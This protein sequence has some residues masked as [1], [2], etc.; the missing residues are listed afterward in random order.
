MLLK[1]VQDTLTTYR[2]L[3]AGDRVLVAV[4]GGPDSVAL[5]HVLYQLRQ[6]YPVELLVAHVHHGLRGSEADQDASFVQDLARQ[7]G[8]PA[9]VQE[10]NVR[11]WQ[12]E[13]GGSLQMAARA[14]RYQCLH[15]IMANEGASKLAL[16]HNADDQAEEI[17]LRI[18]RGAGQR[19]LTGMPP[20]NRKGVIRPLLECHRHEITSY[21]ENRSLAY[22]QDE[23]NLKPWCQ[24]NLLR[25]E[26]LPR[27]QQNF[28]SNLSATLLRTSNIFREEEEFWDALLS[29]WLDQYAIEGE[30]G[31]LR[32]PLGPLLETHPAMQK[33]LLR[34][35]VERVKGDLRSFG[36]HHTEILMQLCRSA[37]AN[38]QIDLPG[39]VKAEKNYSWLT[40]GLR[41]QTP[42]DFYYE[43]AGPGNY[44][45]PRLNH[46]MLLEKVPADLA[47]EL[48]RHPTE[49]LMDLDRVSFPLVLRSSKA[50]DRFRPLGLGGGK[51]LKK[52]FIDAKIPRGQR[53]RIPILCSGEQIIWVV[54]HRLDDRVK[55]TVNT[56]RLLRLL[57]VEGLE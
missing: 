7:L 13:H 10:V 9:V 33:R 32:L 30:G 46:R 12:K 22:R 6:T 42:E 35:V 29:A 47:S 31:G 28:N 18:F 20:C 4:S 45:F 21:L 54:G 3:Q 52:F 24:R 57:Y 27:L 41:Q 53:R 38:S 1:K 48:S 16:G 40:I 26:L 36:F 43:I 34:R 51:K 2:M 49:A 17:L 25:L 8:L 5:C 50:G 14:L 55:V 44:P 11:S 37:A 39:E 23:S 56:S 19:G 15:Q